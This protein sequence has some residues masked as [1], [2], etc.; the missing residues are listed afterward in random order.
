MICAKCKTENP[1]GLKFC[2]ECGAALGSSCASCGFENAPRAKFCG[3]CGAALRSGEAASAIE[4]ETSAVRPADTT[5]T[6]ALEGE[7]KTVTALFADLKGSTELL[8]VLDPEVGRGIV[9][10]LLRIMS[11]AVRRYE[12][13][14]VRTTGDGVFAL[15][16]APVAYEDHPQRALYAALQMQQELHAHAQAQAAK[17]KPALE[18]RVGVHTGEVVAYAGEASGKIEYRLIGHTANLASRIEALAPAGSIAVSDYTAKLCEGYFELR[19]LGATVVKGVSQPVAAYEVLEPGALRTHFELS[20][21]RGLTRF[22]GRERELE[23]L[24]HAL[25]QSVA[26]HG[27]IVAVVA[28]AGTGKSRLFYEFNAMI[29]GSCKVLEAYSV[30]HGKAS[31]WLPLLELLHGYFGIME[32]D[33][34]ASRRGKVRAALT[35]LDPA[36]DDTLPYLFGLMGIVDGPNPHA[37]MDARIKRQRTLEAIKRIILRDSLRQPVVLIFED[38]HWIDEQTQGLLD[39]LADSVASARVLLLFNYRPEYRHEWTNKSC[40]T[41]LRLDP[42]GGADGSAMLTAL[43][44]E[45]GAESAQA[46]NRRAHR[47]ESVFY[48]G[49]CAGAVRRRRASPQRIYQ[50]DTLGVADA[51]AAD[52]AGDA[53]RAHRQATC[54]AERIASDASRRRPG[55]TAR[56][57]EESRFR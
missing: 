53:R 13:Y 10:P 23:Q 45:E 11:D 57:T 2:N 41:H 35:A 24:Q 39:L 46:A 40:Y 21:R 52:G 22:V 49:D 15:F 12:G 4:L 25:E 3:E 1:K 38:L 5:D 30:S 7:R 34:A 48:R 18:A 54:R 37:Q 17:G 27:Q 29:P 56:S 55:I 51:F 8:E 16:G 14:L 28:E 32:A 26:G 9:E 6:G 42:L 47:R 19:S 44:G 20:A 31:P 36:L 50:G 43:L 33:D